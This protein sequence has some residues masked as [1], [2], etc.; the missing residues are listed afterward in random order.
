MTFPLATSG[1][2]PL[3]L[4]TV[5]CALLAAGGP[6]AWCET[7]DLRGSFTLASDLTDRGLLLGPRSP[8]VQGEASLGTPL[9]GMLSI[10]AAVHGTAPRNRR[11]MAHVSR[12]R[13]WSDDWQST[14]DLGWYDYRG[15]GSTP[16]F[17]YAEL[18]VSS[19]FRD[20]LSVATGLRRHGGAPDPWRWVFD[21]GGRWPLAAEWS[22]QGTIGWA[23]LPTAQAAWYRYGGAGIGWQR[24]DWAAGVG[25][26]GADATARAALGR[27]ARPHVSAF[28]AKDF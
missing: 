2:G 26:I 12:A 5:C 15:T 13:A 3:F 11:W 20:L 18:G 4:R 9:Q 7:L 16:N 19:S 8:V 1:P 28:V 14:L 23:Q 10:A 6:A 25:W 17:R 27:D 21:L 22:L 24:Q